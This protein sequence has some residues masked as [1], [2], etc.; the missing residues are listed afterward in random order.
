MEFEEYFGDRLIGMYSLIESS[1]S[2]CLEGFKDKKKKVSKEEGEKA[3]R[4][5]INFAKK[6]DPKKGA[7]LEKEPSRAKQAIKQDWEVYREWRDAHPAMNEVLV[8]FLFGLVGV[9]MQEVNRR[10]ARKKGK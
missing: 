3:R 9:G 5:F 1:N 6:K 7:E 8:L 4:S 10:Q 2:I